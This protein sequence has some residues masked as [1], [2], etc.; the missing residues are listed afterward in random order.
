MPFLPGDSLQPT[1]IPIAQTS[2]FRLQHFQHYV[3]CCKYFIIIIIIIIIKPEDFNLRYHPVRLNTFTVCWLTQDYT[4]RGQLHIVFTC[5]RH[6][7]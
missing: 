6:P 7:T 4:H 5:Y 3:W 2:S 1:L